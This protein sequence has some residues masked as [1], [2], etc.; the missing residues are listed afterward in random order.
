M[1]EIDGTT[2]TYQKCLEKEYVIDNLLKESFK[3]FNRLY[4][5]TWFGAVYV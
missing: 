1:V 2:L 3:F 4:D 5:I